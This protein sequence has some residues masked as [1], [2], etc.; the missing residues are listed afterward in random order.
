MDTLT[1]SEREQRAYRLGDALVM[2]GEDRA[3]RSGLAWDLS[4]DI[5]RTHPDRGQRDGLFVPWQ[6]RAGLDTATATKGQEAKFDQP[7]SFL[8]ALRAE[9]QTIAAGA[10]VLSGLRGDV[11]F[12]RISTTI[13]GVTAVAQNPGSD[14][15][16][17]NLLFNQVALSPK[18]LQASTSYSWQLLRL[19]QVAVGIDTIVQTDLARQVGAIVDQ[20]AIQGSGA[21]NQ[22]TGILSQAGIGSVAIGVNGGPAIWGTM[23]DLEFALSSNNVPTGPDHAGDVAWITTPFQ[24]QQ[25]RKKDRGGATTGWFVVSDTSES[26][27]YKLYTSTSVPSTL[28]KGTAVGICHA[29]LLGRFSE[30]LIGLWGDGYQITVDPYRLKKQG[31]AEVTAFLAYDIGVRHAASFAACKDAT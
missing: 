21:S 24:R 3:E 23:V 11:K 12:P 19:S 2:L 13:P 17:S 14:V 30:L 10:T 9:A 16:D 7:L 20:Y 28:T 1:L 8:D 26:L 15:A 29:I 25:L 6:I 18:L 5:E 22:P 4:Q 27:G 31:M